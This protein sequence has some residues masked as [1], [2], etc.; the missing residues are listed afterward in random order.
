MAASLFVLLVAS[1]RVAAGAAGQKALPA[2]LTVS[3]EVRAA[4]DAA[5]AI[6]AR[7]PGASVQR[8]TG[9]FSDETLR[10]P[11]FGCG[12]AIAGSFARA[13]TTGDA[14]TRLRDD[15]EARAWQEMAEYSAD[16]TDGTSFAFR[17]PGVT[18]LVRGTWNG[19]A[20]GEPSLPAED[21]Y[22]VAVLCT[23]QEVPE[24]RSSSTPAAPPPRR[25]GR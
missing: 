23:S 5:Y 4:C 9:N 10:A 24:N 7:T 16:G 21:W 14:A 3:R 13:Q 22:K 6:A 20:D 12:L 2:P 25:P 1:D 8:R 19:G 15:F 18:C 11:V 17:K